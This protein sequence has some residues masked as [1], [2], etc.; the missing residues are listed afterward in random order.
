MDSE[1]T[2]NGPEI[3]AGHNSTEHFRT[4]YKTFKLT[5][6]EKGMLM[7]LAV[8][9]L[10]LLL[11]MLSRVRSTSPICYCPSGWCLGCIM[12]NYVTINILITYEEQWQTDIPNSSWNWPGIDQESGWNV[13]RMWLEWTWSGP[14][15]TW[16][17][18]GMDLECG[19]NEPGMW[20]EWTWNDL[21]YG[22]NEPRMWLK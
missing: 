4:G 7:D 22:G 14:G 18:V 2:W 12:Q 16:N 5:K 10:K 15:M 1:L 19:G 13:P 8:W 21:E 11:R 9:M 6:K 20:L 3:K 17:M